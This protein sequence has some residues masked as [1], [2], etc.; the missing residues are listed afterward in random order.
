MSAR[1]GVNGRIQERLAVPIWGTLAAGTN[2]TGSVQYLAVDDLLVVYGSV[3]RTTANLGGLVES[4]VCALLPTTHR[5]TGDRGYL[6]VNLSDAISNR[7]GAI[8]TT[9]AVTVLGPVDIGQSVSIHGFV[10]LSA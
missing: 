3:T 10:P 5:P 4:T 8:K 9:G 6:P 2:W 1:L 7:L